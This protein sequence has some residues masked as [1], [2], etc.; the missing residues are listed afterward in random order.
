MSLQEPPQFGRF[1]LC[2][3]LTVLSFVP[4]FLPLSHCHPAPRG[5]ALTCHGPLPAIT[6]RYLYTSELT[7]NNDD[8]REPA[9][10]AVEATF[11]LTNIWQSSADYLAAIAIEGVRFKP[12][13]T[14]GSGKFEAGPLVDGWPVVVAHVEGATGVV[15]ALYAGK[16]TA[17]HHSGHRLEPT[18]LNLVVGFLNA[19]RSRFGKQVS[20][21]FSDFTPVI[22]LFVCSFHREQLKMA[23]QSVVSL[24]P[25]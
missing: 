11:A 12:R 13:S 3:L 9:G 18:Q 5:S 19:L 14:A 21:I 15:K 23:V 20:L 16:D 10:F 8:V 1:L 7:L 25:P 4:P 2:L 6:Y 22:I 24:M 17:T